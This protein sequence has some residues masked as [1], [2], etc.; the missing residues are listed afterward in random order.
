M[1]TFLRRTRPAAVVLSAALVLAACTTTDDDTADGTA[2]AEAPAEGD[3]DT[4]TDDGM[5]GMDHSEDG[6]AADGDL[7]AEQIRTDL[8]HILQEHVVFAALAT[9]AA[10]AGNEEGFG[11]AATALTEGNSVRLADYVGS[12]YGDE[13]RDVFLELWNSHIDMFVRY[14]QAAAGGDQAAADAAVEELVEYSET[15]AAVFDDVTDGAL[16]A[17]GSQPGILEHVTSLKEAVDL[18]IAGDADAAFT[19]LR[20]AAAHMDMLAVALAGA[21]AEQHGIAGDASSDLAAARSK[22]NSLLAEHVWLAGAATGNALAGNDAAFGAA[23]AALTEG[24]SADLAALVGQFYGEDTEAVF[25]DL[26][27]SHIGMFVDYTTG[28]ATGDQDAQVQAVAELTEYVATLASVFESV[29]EGELPASA[30]APLIEEHVLS[31]KA[32]VD[33]QAAGDD[34]YAAALEAGQHMEMIANPLFEAIARQQ[35]AA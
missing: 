27:N 31:T 30:S 14:T 28:V 6:E 13:T 29:T 21:I 20:E 8:S 35:G 11:Q 1:R 24:N 15:L 16:P 10:I 17:E 32:V 25:L 4:D 22:L 12:V 26:W 33:A 7:T 18:Q 34:W 9:D 19:Q 3:E 23:A 2:P 5:D